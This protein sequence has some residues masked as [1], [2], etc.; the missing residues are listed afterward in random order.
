MERK[1]AS[2]LILTI[3]IR[4]Q[5]GTTC[6]NAALSHWNIEGRVK[7]VWYNIHSKV[8]TSRMSCLRDMSSY[9]M[10]WSHRGRAGDYEMGEQHRLL[11]SVL[12]SVAQSSGECRNYGTSFARLGKIRVNPLAPELYIFFNFSTPCI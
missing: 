5:I 6:V 1:N 9:Q 4:G 7:L 11:Q 10:C 8:L 3:L 2:V 12:Y